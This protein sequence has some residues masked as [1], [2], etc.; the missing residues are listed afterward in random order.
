MASA[1]SGPSDGP[2]RTSI[3]EEAGQKLKQIRERLGLKY[4]DVEEASTRICRQ[5]QN[6]EF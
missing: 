4:R 3:M 6:D 1:S 5:H 2:P